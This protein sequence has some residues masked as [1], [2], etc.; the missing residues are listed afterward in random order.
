MKIK[1]LFKNLKKKKENETNAENPLG[2]N[3][4]N[5][6]IKN[7]NAKRKFKKRGRDYE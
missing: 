6:E 4:N 3:I 1:D 2:E 7:N 5:N